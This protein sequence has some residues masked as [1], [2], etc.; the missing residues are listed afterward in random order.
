[1]AK[2]NSKAKIVPVKVKPGDQTGMKFYNLLKNEY[3]IL[4]YLTN[5]QTD[6]LHWDL[7]N[8]QKMD[9]SDAVIISFR[10]TGSNFFNLTEMQKDILQ[11]PENAEQWKLDFETWHLSL[12]ERFFY[13]LEGTMR[14]VKKSEA[15]TLFEKW[16][17]KSIDLPHERRNLPLFESSRKKLTQ[18]IHQSISQN[19]YWESFSENQK[20]T[21]EQEVI[22]RFLDKQ[23]KKTID[24]IFT[25][26]EQRQMQHL[27]PMEMAEFVQVLH[28]DKSFGEYI[29]K[30]RYYAEKNASDRR[31]G[32]K[33]G[34]KKRHEVITPPITKDKYF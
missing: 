34:K 22:N 2:K 31:D 12:N 9:K 32:K 29:D 16:F 5:Y 21:L 24:D 3:K 17:K 23:F 4:E 15:K 27:T 30:L 26:E 33:N 14:E 1:M 11:D 8:F 28:R 13:I 19:R 10:A 18:R 7:E 6:F 25:I 20:T